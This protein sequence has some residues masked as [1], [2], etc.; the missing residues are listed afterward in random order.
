MLENLSGRLAGVVKSLRGQ[1][2]ITEANV[3]DTLRQEL[4]AAVSRVCC[5]RSLEQQPD[6]LNDGRGIWLF[7]RQNAVGCTWKYFKDRRRKRIN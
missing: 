7:R 1:A 3:Q 5:R 6:Q 2:R 4:Q